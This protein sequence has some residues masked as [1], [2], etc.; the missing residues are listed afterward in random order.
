[1]VTIVNYDGPGV[2]PEST[3]GLFVKLRGVEADRASLPTDVLNG[4]GFYAMD[5]STYY[6][7][8]AEN[9]QWREQ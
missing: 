2:M 4:S 5:S 8:D 3:K 1:M 9:A 7:F 6:M